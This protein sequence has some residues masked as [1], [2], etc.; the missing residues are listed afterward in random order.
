MDQWRVKPLSSRALIHY[1]FRLDI[2]PLLVLKLKKNCDETTTDLN[3]MEIVRDTNSIN[4]L[5]K[6]KKFGT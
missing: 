5:D 3:N 1:N 4:Y 6:Q 2:L